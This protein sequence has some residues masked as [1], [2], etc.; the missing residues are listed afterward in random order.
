MKINRLCLGILILIFTI[1]LVS[2]VSA[3]ICKGNDGYYRDCGASYS[4]YSRNSNTDSRTTDRIS[5]SNSYNTYNNYNLDSDYNYNLD[6]DYTSD[7]SSRTYTTSNSYN[8]QEP[9][10]QQDAYSWR[11]Q[12]PSTYSSYPTYSSSYCPSYSNCNSYNKYHGITSGYAG[13]FSP[14]MYS[15]GYDN[16]GYDLGYYGWGW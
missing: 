6:Y 8:K 15:Y 11:Y 1:L 2:F 16:Y 12:Q 7:S 9:V 3:S 13:Y 4:R 14:P 10:Q 5:I